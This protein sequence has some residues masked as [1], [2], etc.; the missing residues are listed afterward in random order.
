M[1][2]RIISFTFT[3]LMMAWLTNIFVEPTPEIIRTESTVN[4]I[5]N[6]SLIYIRNRTY[7]ETHGIPIF[8]IASTIIFF[9]FFYKPAALALTLALKRKKQNNR[10]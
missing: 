6:E 9:L 8:F 2:K 5:R 3:L 10:K 4:N 7:V 1:R